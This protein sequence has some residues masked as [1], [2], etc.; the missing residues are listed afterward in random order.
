M[1][2]QGITG[3]DRR[4]NINWSRIGPGPKKFGKLGIGRTTA[5]NF[6][7]SRTHSNQDQDKFWDQVGPVGPRTGRSQAEDSDSGLDRLTLK[8]F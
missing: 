3:S 6:D 4:T 1:Q 7:K 2:D 5:G 8:L